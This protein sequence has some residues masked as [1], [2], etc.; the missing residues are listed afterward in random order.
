M[1]WSWQEIIKKLTQ[2]ESKNLSVTWKLPEDY[3]VQCNTNGAWRGNRGWRYLE[4]C[5]SDNR[6]NFIYDKAKDI[7][8]ASNMEAETVVILTSL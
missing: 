5:I 8:I 6:R 4:F 7:D 1:R 2:Y 3:Q